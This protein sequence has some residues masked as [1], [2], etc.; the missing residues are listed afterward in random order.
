M[1][2]R[3]CVCVWKDPPPASGRCGRRAGG[4]HPGAGTSGA[5]RGPR[6]LPAGGAAAPA[7][8]RAASAPSLAG[9]GAGAVG[10]A[11]LARAR[12][13]RRVP[14]PLCGAVRAAC[15]VAAAGGALSLRSPRRGGRVPQGP[16]LGEDADPPE[17]GIQPRVSR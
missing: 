2:A 12:A 16:H 3:E 1:R 5:S 4:P 13:T 15:R 14:P 17:A 11:G 9:E 6:A 10:S 7:C 8:G